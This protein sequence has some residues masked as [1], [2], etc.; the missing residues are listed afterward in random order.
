[1]RDEHGGHD[2]VPR[3]GEHHAAP[4]GGG[5][6][7][8][9]GSGGKTASQE[10][11][12]D[13]DVPLLPARVHRPSDLLRLG[14]GVLGI[15][16]VLT[17]AAFAHGTTSG[18]ESDVEKGTQQA[19]ALLISVTGLAASV[20]VLLVPVAF[21]VERLIKRDGLRIADGVLAA[22]LAHG[23]SL[24]TDLWVTE[25]APGSVEDAL[26][27][28]LGEGVASTPVHSYLAPVIA[29]MTAVGM[30]RRPRWR[31]LLWGVLLLDAFAVLIAGYST[32]FS[33]AVTVL[34]GWSVAY[35]TLYAVGS[36]NVRPT[37]QTLL[38]GLR[39]VGFRPRGVM[40][41]EDPDG[42]GEHADHE[43]G[44]RYRVR[45][46]DGSSL[47]V[48]VVDRE[49]QAQ[50]Y[51]YRVWRRLAL[52]GL[53]QPRSTQS[54]RQALEREA[55]ISYAAIAAGANAPRLIAT[56]ELGPDAVML[57]YEHVDGRHLDALPDEE[58]TDGL[59]RATWRQVRALQSRR[60]AH[61]RLVGEALL[62]DRPGAVFL[63]DLRGGEIAAGDLVLRMD[64]AQLLTTFGLRSGAERAV[65][66]AVAVLGPDAVADSLP[67]LQPIALSRGTRTTL[68]RLAKER[69]QREREAVLDASRLRKEAREAAE[70]TYAV[71]HDRKALKAEKHAEKK[72][73][74]EALEGAREE[75]LLARIRGQVLL[76]RPQAPVQPARLERIR[77]RTL[78]T[79]IA[80]AL[81][82]YFLF[83]QL[84]HVEIGQ[85]V[86]GADYSW[87]AIALGFSALT[88][89]AAAIALLGF[90]PEKV[91]FP[92]TVL[93]QV[94]GS[95]VKLV[96]PAAIGGVALNTRFLQ[97]AGVRPGH[98]VASVGAS[99]LVGLGANILLL[100][101]FGY[102]TGTEHTPT[103]SPSRAVIAGLL[104]AAVLVLI[105][106]AVPGLRK[107]VSE[108]L[109]SLFAG[110]VPRM[111]DVVQ[112]PKLLLTGVGGTLL[113]PFAFLMCLD[114]SL[115]AFGYDDM[116]Y[117]T[118]AVVF[119]AG[120]ALGSAAP[121]PGGLGA[122]EAALIAGLITFGVPKEIATPAVLLFRLMTFWLP[123]LPGWLSF[124]QLTRKGAL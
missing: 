101:A 98:A 68:R 57:V 48:T 55:L 9:D 93:A 119:L 11:G 73:L 66:A 23:V 54:L 46:E 17:I 87:V 7:P 60:I 52:R 108:R 42:E 114:A 51:F 45:L 112:R 21:A 75:D 10:D 85:A 56:S 67:L 82:A 24:A 15:I 122:V 39:R 95:F 63:T 123:V 27:K 113:L 70:E 97:R 71:A 118:L 44:R 109:R 50:G 13:A 26:T 5:A 116:S 16:A 47:D 41:V 4:P 38:A 105:V 58:I 88:Y 100:L 32:P 64:V 77:P 19:P 96:A 34:V 103:L 89:L 53:S 86:A 1:M 18:L 59:M 62:V 25:A 121:T 37:G 120:N 79:F 20:A 3:D 83:S 43:R 49:Q 12:I 99:Q 76:T 74:D 22:V 94:A 104:A 6:R 40:A 35:G 115:R 81:A 107:F 29:Y 80:G 69:A 91:P 65:A 124:T 78:I 33:L 2:G 14:L 111:L 106:T 31:V 117:A 28:Q 8:D 92:R 72:A 36:P 102:L 84:S 90:V 30:A 61:R 110:V